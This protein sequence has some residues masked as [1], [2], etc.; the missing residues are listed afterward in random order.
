MRLPPSTRAHLVE[1]VPAGA[2]QEDGAGLGLLA[3]HHEGE[4][5]VADLDHLEQPGAGADV[6]L[7][8][9]LRPG[10]GRGEVAAG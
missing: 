5:L 3:V 4:E 9:L 7:A 6:A 8:D 10:C 1:D 2:A